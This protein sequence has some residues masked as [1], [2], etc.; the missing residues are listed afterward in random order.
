[1][2]FLAFEHAAELID[3]RHIRNSRFEQRS[4]LPVSA[5][6]VVAN[7][8]RER[9]AAVLG[10][11]VNMQLLEP[12]VP[13]SAAWQAIC[14]R[15]QIYG[16]RASLADAA[17]ILR[18]PD[19][20]AL[21]SSAFGETPGAMRDLSAL[22]SQVVVR[23]LHTV[24]DS[25][26]PICGADMTELERISDLRGYATY[27]ELLVERPVAL[28]IGVALSRDPV[29]R[30]AAELRIDDLLDLEFDV[31]AELA[32]GTIDAVALLQLQP[33][34]AIPMKTRIGEP[35]SL[36]VGSTVLA[37]GEGGAAGACNAILINAPMAHT[38][39]STSKRL[40]KHVD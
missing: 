8:V 32:Q 1:M 30:P 27:F 11:P 24:R 31:C 33:N 29:Q 17:F 7:G 6:C 16:V 40:R 13:D 36:K 34:C 28:R 22:E 14:A 38:R 2:I 3:G 15:A 23:A 9:L 18:P 5:A 35:A 39:S 10:L 26:S 12:V 25:L 20:L 19:A 37:H 21:A 4:S